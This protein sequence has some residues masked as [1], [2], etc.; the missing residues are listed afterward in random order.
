MRLRLVDMI[1]GGRSE[2]R[3]RATRHEREWIMGL[4]EKIE[5]RLELQ[6]PEWRAIRRLD[7][8]IRLAQ[9]RMRECYERHAFIGCCRLLKHALKHGPRGSSKH[10]C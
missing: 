2:K 6:M 7:A 4:T 8:G 9:R 1:F 3:R 10:A 5:K